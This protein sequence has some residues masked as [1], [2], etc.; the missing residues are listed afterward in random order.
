MPPVHLAL[1]AGQRP[2]TDEGLGRLARPALRH[3]RAKMRRCAAMPTLDRHLEDPRRTRRR[4]LRQRVLDERQPRRELGVLRFGRCRR[5]LA[6]HPRHHAVV[7]AQLARDGALAPLLDSK[8]TQDFVGQLVRNHGAPFQTGWRGSR[9][10]SV[11]RRSRKPMR[12]ARGP[13]QPQKAQCLTAVFSS[14]GSST[15]HIRVGTG[16]VT[17]GATAMDQPCVTIRVLRARQR[18]CRRQAMRR[19]RSVW[20]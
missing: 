17:S 19:P 1:L 13:Q 5:R 18:R 9:W 4:V 7:Q 3:K 8:Q 6:Q 16:N 2:Q 11:T 10:R 14:E 20:R 12:V 15:T